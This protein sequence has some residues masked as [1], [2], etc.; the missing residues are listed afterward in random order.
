M[1]MNKTGIRS[2]RAPLAIGLAV[3]IAVGVILLVANQS[4]EIEEGKAMTSP[5][6]QLT[7]ELALPSYFPSALRN[8]Q[9]FFS[10]PGV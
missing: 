9:K 5:S 8:P 10:D 3:S 7:I 4:G 6:L 1:L 2:R